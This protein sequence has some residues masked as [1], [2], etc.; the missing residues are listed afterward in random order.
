[1][2]RSKK[3]NDKLDLLYIPNSS[4]ITHNAT[5]DETEQTEANIE[6]LI[7]CVSCQLSKNPE[8]FTR[9]SLIESIIS[10]TS[11]T[12]TKRPLEDDEQSDS[13]SQNEIIDQ[14]LK[15]KLNQTNQQLSISIQIN[16]N[17]LN[18]NENVCNECWIYWK[19]Y[20]GF[21]SNK[22]ETNNCKQK[23]NSIFCNY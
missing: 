5:S 9:K 12:A 3:Q 14:T 10:K 8:S 11:L 7:A 6:N 22:Y 16:T 13:S 2:K 18:S 15:P 17:Q 4:L 21:K 20:G 23:K 1:M 19:K